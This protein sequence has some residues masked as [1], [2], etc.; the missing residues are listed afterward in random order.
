VHRNKKASVRWENGRSNLSN[1]PFA[2]KNTAALIL[3]KS[4]MKLT[5]PG[6]SASVAD[7]GASLGALPIVNGVHPVQIP[8]F[9]HSGGQAYLINSAYATS[10]FYLGIGAAINGNNDR[11]LHTGG[12]SAGCIT[13]SPADWTAL[14][15]VI[16]TCRR[17]NNVDVGTVT[18]R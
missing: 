13:M 15:K 6:G 9:P 5:Y 3:T 4:T 11:Y 10:W 18:V 8:D 2:Y 14:Y 17:G 16:I 7:L 1:T 12:A